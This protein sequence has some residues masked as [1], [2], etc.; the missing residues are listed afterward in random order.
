ML[1]IIVLSRA[2]A[3][4]CIVCTALQHLV[5]LLLFELQQF[6]IKDCALPTLRWTREVQLRP[7]DRIESNSVI[8]YSFSSCV[9]CAVYLLY[10]I[11]NFKIN[12]NV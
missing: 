1:Q 5:V 3:T 12:M 6:G 11:V 8:N 2:E 9:L 4:V 10:V 7:L